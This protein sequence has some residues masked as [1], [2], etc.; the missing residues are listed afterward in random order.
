MN[1]YE[2]LVLIRHKQLIFRRFKELVDSDTHE[3]QVP[4]GFLESW[5]KEIMKQN[6]DKAGLRNWERKSLKTFEN[7]QLSLYASCWNRP[8]DNSSRESALMWK[9]YAPRG[10][11]IKSEVGKLLAAKVRNIPEMDGISLRCERIVYA[12][13]WN[14]LMKRGV[15]HGGI[16][17][18]RLFL[19][20][21]RKAFADENEVRFSF[22]LPFRYWNARF[23][24][25]WFGVCFED[26]NW[27]DEVV[28]ESS[29]AEWAV[30]IVEQLVRPHGLRFSRSRI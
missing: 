16:F 2:F 10:I 19:H 7:L 30:Q 3:G 27:I 17:M 20:A 28:A 13:H 9:A 21:K 11:A 25:S 22:Q 6:P 8:G 18:G 24:P 15:R 29:L 26:L 23:R 4:P 12:D 14:Q 1:V 5:K